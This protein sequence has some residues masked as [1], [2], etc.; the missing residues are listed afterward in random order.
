VCHRHCWP[1]DSTGFTV[2]FWL[3]A[4]RVRLGAGSVFSPFSRTSRAEKKWRCCEGVG[5]N[6][7]RARRWPSYRAGNIGETATTPPG[8]PT[9]AN[10]TA[11]TAPGTL[12]HPRHPRHPDL[13]AGGCRGGA[14]PEIGPCGLANHRTDPE[15]STVV[16]WCFNVIFC[17]DLVL[18]KELSNPFLTQIIHPLG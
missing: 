16:K 2:R 9:G 7:F 15:I 4:P 6:Y 3:P 14:R 12:R 10:L 18:D 17:S 8:P 13:G 1:H 11:P 5:E